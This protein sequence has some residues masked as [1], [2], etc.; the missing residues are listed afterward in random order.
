[1]EELHKLYEPYLE[2]DGWMESYYRPE[3]LDLKKAIAAIR[4]ELDTIENY[5]K[6]I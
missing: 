4:N 5:V 2:D 3:M 1:M 6:N